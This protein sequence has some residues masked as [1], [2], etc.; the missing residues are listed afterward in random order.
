MRSNPR[1]SRL[2]LVF[3]VLVAALA[4]SLPLGARADQVPPCSSFKSQ[5]AAQEYFVV[6]GGTIN[7]QIGGLDSDHDGVACE[8]LGGPYEGYATLAYSQKGRSLYGTA[9]MPSNPYGYSCMVGN[10]HY[11]EGGRILNVYKVEPRGAAKPIIEQFGAFAEP[12]P[13]SGRLVW[14]AAKK[15]IAPGRYYVEFEEQVRKTPF[16]RSQCPGFR[17]RIVE[18]P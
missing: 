7:R 16:E 17:S 3:A 9:T 10:T 14:R 5:A 13:A 4:L 12:K 2:S 18:L 6:A 11:S 1:P 8:E 15:T